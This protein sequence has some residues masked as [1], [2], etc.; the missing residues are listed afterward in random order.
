MDTSGTSASSTGEQPAGATAQPAGSDVPAPDTEVLLLPVEAAPG[1]VGRVRSWL[2]S[3]N[4]LVVTCHVG[5]SPETVDALAGVRVYASART[6][7]SQA[8]AVFEAVAQPVRDDVLTLT[9]VARL[10]LEPRRAAVRVPVVRPATVSTG[11]GT[12]RVRTLDLSRGGARVEL[13]PGETLPTEQPLDLALEL[14]P[15]TQVQLSA[16]VARVDEDAA[17]ASLRFLHVRGEDA[18]QIER[19]V[20]RRL[21]G[22]GTSQDEPQQD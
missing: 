9:G 11:E 20:L 12:L 5:T 13:Q 15:D 10:A 7:E 17:Q 3:P 8:L 18:E 2:T 19:A 1:R 16:Q 21:S 14:D 6:A 4:G 22:R